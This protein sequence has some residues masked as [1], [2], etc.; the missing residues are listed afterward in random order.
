MYL[1]VYKTFV[2]TYFIRERTKSELLKDVYN[3]Y[4]R[5]DVCYDYKTYNGR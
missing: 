3:I 5:N 4:H 1:L 2:N